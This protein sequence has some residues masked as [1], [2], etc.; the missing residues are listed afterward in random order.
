[1]E[2]KSQEPDAIY[3]LQGVL[4]L[5]LG[6]DT[7][8][9]ATE[10]AVSMQPMGGRK[11]ELAVHTAVSLFVMPILWVFLVGVCFSSDT[12]YCTDFP[13]RAKHYV[14]PLMAIF[15]NKEIWLSIV[16]FTLSVNSAS[17]VL[18]LFFCFLLALS[19]IA[20]LLMHGAYATGQSNLTVVLLL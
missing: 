11:C 13:C 3:A 17:P 10:A 8:C 2:G 4:L 15:R 20:T 6:F 18:L 7:L 1:M 12:Y 19:G 14:Y 9:A 16:Q 5:C